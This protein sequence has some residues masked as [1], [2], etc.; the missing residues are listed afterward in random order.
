VKIAVANHHF[1]MPPR[2]HP[3]LTLFQRLLQS[4][5]LGVA[6]SDARVVITGASGGI[7]RE[8]AQ[9]LLRGCAERRFLDFTNGYSITG[10]W[11]GT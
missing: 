10:W 2:Y 7:G 11:F 5:L 8:L 6:G 4:L 3:F 1:P 9:Q